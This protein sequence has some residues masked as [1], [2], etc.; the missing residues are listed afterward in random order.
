MTGQSPRPPVCEEK[1][2]VNTLRGIFSQCGNRPRIPLPIGRLVCSSRSLVTGEVMILNF[3][4]V[5]M[6]PQPEKHVQLTNIF[7]IEEFDI[8]VFWR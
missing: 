8:G 4:S 2:K 6:T 7:M 1:N 5:F 3:C